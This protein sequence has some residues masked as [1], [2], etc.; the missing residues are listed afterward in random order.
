MGDTSPNKNINSLFSDL[1]RCEQSRDF[2]KALRVANK[3]LKIENDNLKALEYKIICQIYSGAFEESLKEIKKNQALRDTL[4]FEKAYC[5]YRL[6]K[7]EDCLETLKK[8]TEPDF[9]EKEL[10]CQALYRIGRYKECY[11]LYLDL[12]KNSNDEYEDE[13]EA[14]LAA[15]V[16]C[17]SFENSKFVQS[18]DELSD[19][20]YELCY[21]NSCIELGKK[22]YESA[23]KKLTAAE[24]LCRK[25]LEEEGCDNEEIDAELA[26][27]RG[28]MGFA[29][30]ALNK[31]DLAHKM[32]NQLLKMKSPDPS[33]IA[34]VSNNIVTIN[35]DQ[36]VF[37]SRK[38]MKQALNEV[39]NPKL[40]SFQKRMIVFNNC[41]LLMTTNQTDT[42]RKQI[43]QFKSEFP[44]ARQ[45]ALILE[46]AL[47]CKEKKVSDAIE[48]LKK[49][50][51]KDPDN[52]EAPLIM[53]Q[54]LLNQG[55]S[56]EAL[57]ILKELKYS[58]KLAIV[59]IIVALHLA[60]EDKTEAIRVLKEAINWYQSNK[61]QELIL[62][63]RETARLLMQS[64]DSKGA[65]VLLEELRKRNPD[66]PQV[67]AQ[68]IAA[69]SQID[70][71]K[72]KEVMQKLPSI[73]S[74]ISEVDVDALEASNWSLGAKYVK[75]TT[76]ADAS[77]NVEEKTKKKKKKKKKKLPKNYDPDVDPNPERWIPKW[78]RSTFKK[79]K[80]KRGAQ[81]IGKG[82]QGSTATDMESYPKTTAKPAPAQVSPSTSTRTQR[83]AQ[84]KQKKKPGRK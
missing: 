22:K 30:Q 36:N 38:K 66:N 13:R 17:L 75:K 14:D 81:S 49:Y 84:K 1:S 78:Q 58:H 83:L 33:L 57:S 48:V 45:E 56:G 54:L 18:L 51:E 37:D 63:Y 42:C 64:K 76:K 82:T 72:A 19:K 59:S 39:N 74:Q 77:L 62:L 61:S 15:V 23:L 41:L 46:A 71:S 31:M 68:L 69:Y 53:V 65:I 6:N 43:Q 21:N 80:D 79:K 12:I 50:K 60:L 29:Y 28:Q 47:L 20:T 7:V 4:I 34:V 52:F 3:I 9:R 44:S 27:I 24:E 70:P 73:E 5:E 16:A 40:S 25:T 32:Y 35:K 8:S 55:H 11:D 26:T 10:K 2:D 67:L